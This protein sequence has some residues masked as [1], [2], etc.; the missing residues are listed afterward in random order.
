M[1]KLKT[2]LDNYSTYTTKLLH[3]W[4]NPESYFKGGD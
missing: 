4:L 1:T 3:L 2:S